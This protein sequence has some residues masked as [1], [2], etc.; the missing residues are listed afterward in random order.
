MNAPRPPAP[1]AIPA[2]LL[3]AAPP[4]RREPYRIFFPLG[5]LLAWG[6]ILHWLLHALGVLAHYQPVFHSIAQIQGFMMCFAIGFLFTAI[7]RR[8]GTA[9]PAAW[10]MGI[11]LAAPIGSTVSAWFQT[12][13]MLAISQLFWFVLVVTLFQFAIRRFRSAEAVRRPPNSFIWLP[14]SF[15]IGLVGSA[16]TGAAGMLGA[17]LF[18]LHDLGRLL[19]LQGMF[20]GLVVGVGGMVLPLVTRGDAPPDGAATARDR[21]IRVGHAGVAIALCATFWLETRVSVVAGYGARAALVLAVLLLSS[22]IWRLPTVPGWHR[23]LVWLS[24]WMIPAG[25]VLGALF[26]LERKAGLHLVFIGGFA[27]MALSVGIHVTLAHGGHAELVKG[28]PW[29]V[30]VVGGLLL[31]AATCRALVDFDQARFFIWL[32]A[33]S[34]CFLAAT[35]FWG[36]LILPRLASASAGDAA[37]KIRGHNT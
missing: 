36:W 21:W 4:W 31:A 13:L 2:A 12:P 35:I 30:P 22:R 17:D 8:T 32:G 20:L 11:G 23:K 9:P 29:Q 15:A 33:A 5:A 28:R 7:P 27:A 19:L 37:R 3:A 10:E 24:A 16:L 25:Y 14:L 34:A 1:P 26:P 18:W 6:G